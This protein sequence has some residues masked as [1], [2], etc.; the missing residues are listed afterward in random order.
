M[1]GFARSCSRRGFLLC[2]LAA[3]QLRAQQK[4]P[5]EVKRYEDPTTDLD[6]YRLTDPAN[7]STLPAYYSRSIARNSGSLLFCCDRSGT[8]QAFRLDLKTGESKELTEAED[9]DGS[10]LTLTPDNRSFCYFAGR[11]L[12]ISPMAGRAR[13]LYQVPEGW[14]RCPGMNVGPD[15]THATFAER[16]GDRS[17][18]RMVTLVQGAARTVVEV[19]FAM[20]H[21]IARPLRAQILFRQGDEALWLVNS[22]GTQKRQLKLAGGR[23]GPANWAADGKSLLYLNFPSDPIQITTIRECLP[24]NNGD[25]LVAKTSQYAHF[26]FNVPAT[27]FVGACRSAAS[28]TILIMLRST[29]RELTLC[30]HKASHPEMTAPRF[31]PDTQ[32][33]YFQSDREGKPAIYSMHME[34]FLDR[35]DPETGNSGQA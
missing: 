1:D 4:F 26:G 29:R 2:G 32:R 10:S 23:V 35:T 22:D 5:A 11:S 33:M 14:E 13:P 30:E 21:P 16:Q 7:A 25:S 3:S 17:R 19:P 24:D 12:Y 8:P 20:S 6:V 31:S 9:L 28:P 18:L 34:K 15:G 27:V